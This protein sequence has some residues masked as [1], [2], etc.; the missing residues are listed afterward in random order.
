MPSP[1]R[2]ENDFKTMT[3]QTIPKPSKTSPKTI[4]IYIYIYKGHLFSQ[5]IYFPSMGALNKSS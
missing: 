4:Y 5:E 2:P 3:K 1:D